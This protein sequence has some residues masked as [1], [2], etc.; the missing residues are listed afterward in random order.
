LFLSDAIDA[1]EKE[2]STGAVVASRASLPSADGAD[3][4]TAIFAGKTAEGA[5]APMDVAACCE[6]AAVAFDVA[7]KTTPLMKILTREK[8]Q[9][10]GAQT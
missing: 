5:V 9:T 8:L 6:V 10:K 7:S 3:R 2:R 1:L 4:D